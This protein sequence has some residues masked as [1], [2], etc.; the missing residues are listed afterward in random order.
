MSKV[1]IKKH[2]NFTK[3]PN[4]KS[5]N[6]KIRIKFDK[7]KKYYR[8]LLLFF[9]RATQITERNEKKKEKKKASPPFY[10]VL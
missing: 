10:C 6:K 9:Y 1:E 5:S 7:K 8:T 2:I 3:D 4:T